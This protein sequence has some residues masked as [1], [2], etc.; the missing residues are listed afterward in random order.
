VT[1]VEGK[2]KEKL[3]KANGRLRHQYRAALRG[4][5]GE[6]SDDAAAELRADPD[7]AYVE[8]DQVVT[9]DATQSGA[10]WGI[11]RIDQRS[12]PLSG[13][14]TYTSTG[15]GVRAYI[16]DTGILTAHTSSAGGRATCTTASAATGRTATGTA[17]TWRHGRR[18]G[19]RRGEGGAAARRARVPVLGRSSN[20]TIIAGIDWVTRNHVK[21]AVA[22]L[23]LGGGFSQASNDAVTR[24]ANAGVFVAVAAGNSN[25]NACNTSPASAPR[26]HG[27]GEHERRREG[28]VLEL[29]LVRGPVR[30]R[31]GDHERV[32][33]EHDGDEHDQRHVDGRAARG[34][35]GALYKAA[36]GE[37]SQ[38]TIDGWLKTN[39]TA[40]VITG[41]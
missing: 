7:V 19:V 41:T 10:T 37:A 18:R 5:A 6:L 32:V 26:D 31:L 36:R 11:D 3:Q 38:A 24:L 15:S 20:S 28:V 35:R 33:H 39:A 17:R 21:P 30:A 40:N 23:S 9:V 1:D 14:Y 2:T 12:R 8:Q 25:A 4:F 22:N 16:I 13:T 34:R 29:R 27:G